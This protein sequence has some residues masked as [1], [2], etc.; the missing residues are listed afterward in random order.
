MQ[1]KRRSEMQHMIDEM[2]KTRQEAADL[3]K[4]IAIELGFV[5]TRL[6]ETQTVLSQMQVNYIPKEKTNG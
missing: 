6:A 5:M 3:R 4:Q 2:A 1:S